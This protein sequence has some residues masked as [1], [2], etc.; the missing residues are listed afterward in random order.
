MAEKINKNQF[1]F[2]KAYE[3]QKNFDKFY[4]NRQ[5]KQ[6]VQKTGEGDEDFIIVQ[7]EVDEKIDIVQSIQSQACDAGIDAFLKPYLSSNEPVPGVAVS[8][9]VNDFTKYPETLADAI[10]IG[11]KAKVAFA[12]L[13]P[14][15]TKG[16]DFETFIKNMTQDAF[17]DY[18][19]SVTPKEEE[20]PKGKEE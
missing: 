6:V 15:L 12:S 5:I 16:Q 4:I 9:E 3:G 10:A 11:E 18:L 7:K 13:D 20:T 2:L 17:L 1:C 19:N 14:N 8:N